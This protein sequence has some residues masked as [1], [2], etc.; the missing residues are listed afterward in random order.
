MRITTLSTLCIASLALVFSA[1]ANTSD[2][3]PNNSQPANK[4]TTAV[5]TNSNQAAG[6]PASN[7]AL[8]PAG[9]FEGDKIQGELQTGKTE[10]VI[11][12]FGN[13]SGDYAGYCFANDSEP[14]RAILGACKD[15][16]QCEVLAQ[17]D[18]EGGCKVPG[19]EANLSASGK[20]LRVGSA[21]SVGGKQ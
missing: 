17:I 18:Y 20:I 2:T 19:L 5:L 12:Y 10:S 3:A 21:K 16:A 8:T 6:N 15:R 11:L 9:K 4:S 13:Q 1:C 7:T 14:G